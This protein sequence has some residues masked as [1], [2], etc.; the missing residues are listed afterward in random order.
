[1]KTNAPSQLSS[2][3]P[4]PMSRSRVRN[5]GQGKGAGTA[6]NVRSGAGGA[7]RVGEEQTLNVGRA[8]EA[9]A[10]IDQAASRPDGS[11]IETPAEAAEL[12]TKVKGQVRD[13]ADQA[14]RAQGRGVSAHLAE[15]LKDK[16][17]G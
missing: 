8:Q 5:D 1:M 10:R 13:N 4:D 9:Y 17:P 14:L 2:P 11:M 7:D 15:L 12:V 3:G 6:D 16:A